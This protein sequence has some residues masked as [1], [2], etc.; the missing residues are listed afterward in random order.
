MKKTVKQTAN[1]ILIGYHNKQ[2]RAILKHLLSPLELEAFKRRYKAFP[3]NMEDASVFI[4]AATC[5]QLLNV[6]RNKINFFSE[7]L[8]QESGDQQTLIFLPKLLDDPKVILSLPPH[9]RN[10]LV[11]RLDCHNLFDVVQI[12]RKQLSQTRGLG[13][14]GL[15]MLDNLFTA[16]NCGHLFS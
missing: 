7:L 6:T 12:G 9:L 5:K 11:G 2:S 3:Y 1:D 4:T 15:K 14:G 10:I 8:Q 13:K 16:Y